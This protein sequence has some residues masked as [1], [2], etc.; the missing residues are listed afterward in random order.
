[1]DNIL[2]LKH[3]EAG[4]KLEN[5]LHDFVLLDS[6]KAV[7]YVPKELY[8][9]TSEDDYLRRTILQE[10][11]KYL[12]VLDVIE[13]LK[14]LKAIEIVS[15]YHPEKHRGRYVK[16]IARIRGFLKEVKEQ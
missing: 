8:R 12:P 11:D 3:K 14:R 1:M 7:L 13:D 9:S 15:E 16:D 5:R 6:E 2:T 4:L 10:A